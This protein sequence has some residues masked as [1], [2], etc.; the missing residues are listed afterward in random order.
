MEECLL[1][2]FIFKNQ[3]GKNNLSIFS[4]ITKA[5]DPVQ[6]LAGFRG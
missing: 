5:A 4:L 2:A 6:V 3:P 1:K